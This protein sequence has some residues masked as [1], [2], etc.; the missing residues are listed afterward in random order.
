MPAPPF[1]VDSTVVVVVVVIAATAA[2]AANAANAA[3]TAAITSSKVLAGGDELVGSA[4]GSA[5]P[6]KRR[7]R[8][9]SPGTSPPRPAPRRR[10]CRSAS[11]SRRLGL[12]RL[13]GPAPIARR[14]PPAALRR[15]RATAASTAHAPTPSSAEAPR[16]RVPA[17]EGGCRRGAARAPVAVD[18]GR[19][20]RGP[21]THRQSRF[22]RIRRSPGTAASSKAAASSEAAAAKCVATETAGVEGGGAEQAR[23]RPLPQVSAQMPQRRKC[24]CRQNRRRQS[25]HRRRNQSRHR[26]RCQSHW[27]H[28]HRHCRRGRCQT[29][30]RIPSTQVRARAPARASG[31]ERAPVPSQEALSAPVQ[32]P[33]FCPSPH[34]RRSFA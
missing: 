5:A 24:R 23:A 18:L 19:G 20:R 22:R 4:S 2:T 16:R 26:L 12:R 14:A 25:R 3:N 33:A 10:R 21:Q 28:R 34:R 29:S 1:G 6:M 13:A 32:V 27:I 8:G 11:R 9:A 15:T 31:W 30:P 17:P 7:A